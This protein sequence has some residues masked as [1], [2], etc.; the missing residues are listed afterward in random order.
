M[1]A[2]TRRSLSPLEPLKGNDMCVKQIHERIR[3]PIL[4][5]TR[6]TGKKEDT[7]TAA[8]ANRQLEI[9]GTFFTR[10]ESVLR[11]SKTPWKTVY[12]SFS[13]WSR[14]AQRAAKVSCAGIE[15]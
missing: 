8:P 10:V 1:S 4:I 14:V 13:W 9:A 3:A 5:P 15:D 6:H 12:I 11:E 7:F 2:E